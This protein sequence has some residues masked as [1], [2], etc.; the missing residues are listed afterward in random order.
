V[1]TAIYDTNGKLVRQLVSGQQQA[2]NHWV[3][4]NARDDSGTLV[5]SGVY[6]TMLKVEDAAARGTGFR[7]TNKM[8]L[9]K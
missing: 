1:D 3:K 8:I 5:S 9:M 2:G 6:F 7:Q 4:W